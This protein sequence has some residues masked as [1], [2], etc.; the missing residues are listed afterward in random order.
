MPVHPAAPVDV[1]ELVAAYRQT[2]TSFADVADGLRDEE[3][4]RPT[5]LPGWTA[6]DVLAHVVHIEDYLSGSEH[7]VSGWS[8]PQEPVEVGSPDHVRNSFAVWNEEGI[9]ARDERSPADLVAELRGLLEVRSAIMYDAD[10]ELDTVVR[11]VRGKEGPFGDVTRLRIMDVW[12]HE[13]D[14]RDVV[15]RPGSLDSPGASAFMDLVMESLCDVVLN[16][17]QPEPGTVVILEST[18]PVMARGGVRIGQDADGHPVAHELFTGHTTAEDDE[19]SVD[20]E[21]ADRATTISMSTYYLARRAGGRVATED[22]A[23]QVVG[24]EDLA[25]R[26][27]DALV[28]TP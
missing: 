20:D 13:Q 23:Y 2:L 10:L 25:R 14:L 4:S 22:T 24:D 15:D 7:P 5:A 21:S 8:D 1:T 6:R 28:L 16:R 11:T 19:P 9:R 12:L 27:L 3:W 18:G 17:V 26:V